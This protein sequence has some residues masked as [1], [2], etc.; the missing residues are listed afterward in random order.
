MPVCNYDGEVIGVAQIMNKRRSTMRRPSTRTAR[1]TVSIQEGDCSE[2][3]E[4]EDKDEGEDYNNS[5]RGGEKPEFTDTD[6]KVIE[7]RSCLL[8]TSPSPRD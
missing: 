5:S 1:K 6:I 8:Y 4:E 3:E 2:E 7:N